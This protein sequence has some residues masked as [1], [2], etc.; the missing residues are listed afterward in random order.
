M[1]LLSDGGRGVR[2]NPV[3]TEDPVALSPDG[4]RIAIANAHDEGGYTLTVR[5]TRGQVFSVNRTATP[6]PIDRRTL[7]KWTENKTDP[8]TRAKIAGFMKPRFMSPATGVLIGT[9]NFTWVR[10]EGTIIDV[11]M[12]PADSVQWDIFDPGG[13]LVGILRLPMKLRA[14]AAGPSTLW[15]AEEDEN[16]VWQLVRFRLSRPR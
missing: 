15:A 8:E 4:S 3:R 1:G 2:W 6:T 14:F 11:L 7:E 9:D 12:V 13:K 10:R 5:D 16:G